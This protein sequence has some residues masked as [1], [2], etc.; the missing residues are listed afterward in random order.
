MSCTPGDCSNVF[1]VP[2]GEAIW[3]NELRID[4]GVASSAASSASSVQGTASPT[5]TATVTASATCTS[6]ITAAPV[7]ASAT[8]TAAGAADRNSTNSGVSTAAAAAIGVAIGVPLLVALAAA[9]FMLRQEKKK[10]RNIAPR[11]AD[12]AVMNR[13]HPSSYQSQGSKYKYQNPP[14]AFGSHN[15]DYGGPMGV[16]QNPVEIGQNTGLGASEL[17]GT[18]SHHR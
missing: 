3:N 5:V 7:T 14:L 1:D 8:C 9:L 16:Q 12:A 11:P 4:L 18:P 13:Q 15:N 17:S 6:A 10:K 2:G